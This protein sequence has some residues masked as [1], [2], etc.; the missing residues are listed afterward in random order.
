MLPQFDDN[1]AFIW[2]I[3]AIGLTVPAL[4]GLYAGLKARFA[5]RRLERL[6]ASEKR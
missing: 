2:A 6:Q 1:A 4:L 3:F 5:K